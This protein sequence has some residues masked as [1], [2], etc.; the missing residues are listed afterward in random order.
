[1][2]NEKEMIGYLKDNLKKER[3]QHSINVRDTSIKLAEVFNADKNKAKISGLLH[4]CGKYLKN[5]E[6][7]KLA[8]KNNITLDIVEKTNPQLLH[9]LAGS[10]IARDDMGIEDSEILNAIAFHTTG[11]EKM[12]LLEKIV[13]IADYIEP[14][15]QF[16]GIDKIRNLAFKDLDNA[17][18]LS[19]NGTIQFILETDKLI[20]KN[21][22]LARN[23]LLLERRE[24][25]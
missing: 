18:I 9:G 21:T 19:F 7:I 5:T 10:I 22:I 3:F 1:M 17:L 25:K 20:H 12:S 4:D 24:K 14:S 16:D 11:K 23:Y 2:W 6:L 13:F 8:E 15:R